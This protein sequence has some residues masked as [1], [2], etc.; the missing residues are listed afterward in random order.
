MMTF[1]NCSDFPFNFNL[2]V[3]L[4]ADDLSGEE[5]SRDSELIMFV[6][7]GPAS[8]TRWETGWTTCLLGKRLTGCSGIM[9]TGGGEYLGLSTQS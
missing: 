3:N 5:R 8:I 1:Y 2:I 9:I 7:K 4:K 6:V